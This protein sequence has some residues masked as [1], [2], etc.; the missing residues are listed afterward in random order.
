MYIFIFICIYIIYI[1]V[2]SL[3]CRRNN[4]LMTS[5]AC[6]LVLFKMVAVCTLMSRGNVGQV[7]VP[8]TRSFHFAKSSAVKLPSR[9]R[10]SC[11]INV[12]CCRIFCVSSTTVVKVRY[13]WKPCSACVR[14]VK[15]A[16]LVAW[17]E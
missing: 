17:N 5:F 7:V 13:I 1:Y 15:S 12:P 2:R 9:N 16:V 3:T 10:C 4:L 6:V 8:I 14:D 11:S